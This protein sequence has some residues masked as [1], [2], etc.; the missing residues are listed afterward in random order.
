MYNVK[1]ILQI[2]T[3][4]VTPFNIAISLT[5]SVIG[6]FLNAYNIYFLIKN[7]LGVNLSGSFVNLLILLAVFDAIFLLTGIGLFGLPA[8]SEWYRDNL[9]YNILPNG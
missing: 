8:V 9:F 5:V 4:C 3:I 6:L 1:M 2:S 7:R